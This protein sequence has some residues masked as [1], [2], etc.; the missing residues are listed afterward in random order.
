MSKTDVRAAVDTEMLAG[1]ITRRIGQQKATR[2]GDFV[3]FERQADIHARL[4]QRLV[5]LVEMQG[6]DLEN[7]IG[8]LLAKIRDCLR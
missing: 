2:S 5:E 7:S 6:F 4:E 1:D 3:G 8:V